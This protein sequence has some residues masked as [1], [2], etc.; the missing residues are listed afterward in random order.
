M[1]AVTILGIKIVNVVKVLT[2]VDSTPKDAQNELKESQE[3]L[4][5]MLKFAQ[6][7]LETIE[8]EETRCISSHQFAHIDLQSSI[9]D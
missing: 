7:C 2:A 5:G 4:K 8:D 6:E 9:Q 1:Y 3:E